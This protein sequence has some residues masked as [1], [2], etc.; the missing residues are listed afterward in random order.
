MVEDK[1]QQIQQK[2]AEVNEPE[3]CKQVRVKVLEILGNGDYQQY[4]EN[5][6][7]CRFTE[8]NSEIVIEILGSAPWNFYVIK[9]KLEKIGIKVE[10]INNE[11]KV[12]QENG[13]TA[14][15]MAKSFEE[16]KTLSALYLQQ[17]K[18][19]VSQRD[20]IEDNVS[21]TPFWK[22]AFKPKEQK[23]P[24]KPMTIEE[25][26]Q[27]KAEFKKRFGT[28]VT[29]TGTPGTNAPMPDVSKTPSNTN[30][31]DI[32]KSDISKY[33]ICNLMY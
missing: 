19:K 21:D 4:F 22:R 9:E 5:Q 33:S 26:Q 17:K 23:T 15:C 7:K 31:Y 11:I 18:R 32:D 1:K 29:G 8:R 3:T 25:L 16:L 12:E 28:N 27:L 10:W 20:N 30:V 6:N 24:S 14:Y 13:Y 2:I